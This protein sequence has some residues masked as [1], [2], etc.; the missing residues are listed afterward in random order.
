MP[1]PNLTLSG[2]SFET[3]EGQPLAFGYLIMQ[4]SHD[5]EYVA[6]PYQI[7]AGIKLK[8]PL[9]ANGN[10]SPAVNVWSNDVISPTG[11]YYDVM[12][13]EADGTQAFRNEQ[14]WILASSP[15]PLNVGSVIPANPPGF[16]P[17]IF[18]PRTG[19]IEYVIDG[20]GSVP[21]LG[22]YGQVNIPNNCTVTGWVLTADQT[23]SAVVD[24]LT[25]TFAA[26]PTVSSIAGADKPTISA[27]QKSENLAVT[28]W[29]PSIA[30]G[31]QMQFVLN[32]VSTINRLNICVNVIITS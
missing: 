24:V 29:N 20:G 25:S 28:L 26:F 22:S 18:L 31:T 4:L 10:I 8:I 7:V 23:G 9:D 2:G 5:A 12:G 27:N 30:A 3:F 6:G 14:F 21:G 1:V 16:L 11:S 17:P 13:Y 15:S 32:S 19:A